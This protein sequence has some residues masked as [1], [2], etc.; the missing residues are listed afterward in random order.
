MNIRDHLSRSELQFFLKTSN[1]RGFFAF[2]VSWGISFAA[3]ALAYYFPTP[4]VILVAL[5]ILGGR[6]LG[7]AVLIHEATHQSLF[8]SRRLN[9][10]MASW[11]AAY[12]LWFE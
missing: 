2:A 10:F 4:I 1:A 3:L 12:P 8:T 9:D 6:Q 11:F 5:A 7:L